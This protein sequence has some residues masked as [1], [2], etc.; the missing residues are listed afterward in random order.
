MTSAKIG[1]AIIASGATTVFGFLALVASPF[2]M[3]SNFGK[4]TVID[5]LLALLATFVVFPPLIVILDTWR[6]KRKGA[7]TTDKEPKKQIQGAEV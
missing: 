3:I 2:P 4:V 6:D 5:V 7:T 1:T